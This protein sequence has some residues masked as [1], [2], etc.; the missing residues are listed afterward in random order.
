MSERPEPVL[1]TLREVIAPLIEADSGVLHVVAKPQGIRLHL[2]GACGGCAGVKTCTSDVFDPALRAAG[3]KGD[4]EI[5][6]GW[7]VPEGAER[8]AGPEAAASIDRDSPLR[9]S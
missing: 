1:R 7:I 4:I 9:R 2:A 8:I 3:V 6:A 5:S